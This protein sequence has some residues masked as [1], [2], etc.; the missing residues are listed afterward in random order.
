MSDGRDSERD[1]DG[2]EEAVTALV[3][4]QLRAARAEVFRAYL[5][6]QDKARALAGDEDDA[7]RS[8]AGQRFQRRR[9]S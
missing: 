2:G 6:A 9:G 8:A 4:Q 3:G 1:R 5:Q 7:P